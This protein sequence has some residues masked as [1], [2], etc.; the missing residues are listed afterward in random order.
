MINF[1]EITFIEKS[2]K[3]LFMVGLI[4]LVRKRLNTKSSKWA[5][6]SLWTIFITYLLFPYTIVFNLQEPIKNRF[7]EAIIKPLVFIN[8][9]SRVIENNLGYILSKNNQLIVSIILIGYVLFEMYKV[10]QAMKGSTIIE[11][12]HHVNKLISKFKLRRSIKVLINDDLK[13]PITYGVFKPKIILQSYILK[14]KELLKYVMIHELTHIKKYDIVYNHLKNLIACLYWHNLLILAATRY[15]EED[16]EILCDKL[17][18][19]KVGDTSEHRKEY[20]ISMLKL[21]DKYK[22][23]DEKVL[24]L[25]PTLERMI[26]MRK[27]KK[28]LS[29][30]LTFALVIILSTTAFADVRVTNCNTLISSSETPIETYINEA[31]RVTVISDEE[32]RDLKLEELNV[33][34]LSLR[35]ANVSETTSLGGLEN[36]YYKFNM[37]SRNSPTHNGFTVKLSNMSSR[38]NL[39]YSII[40]QENGRVI[41][42]ESFNKA[43]ILKVTPDRNYRYK[44]TIVNNS[45]DS[46]TYSIKINSYVR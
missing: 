5:N 33:E 31:D 15:I 36:K 30:I 19:E 7:V 46:M 16:I 23:R 26:V 2:F 9:Y 28:T 35:A 37:S 20:C 40:I 8:E 43:T 45:V 4:L 14:D 38:S 42:K 22:G 13:T 29:G 27:C 17:V 1:V 24:K 39:D 21:M 41:Y 10:E 11:N 6:I 12:N 18:V 34:S 32:Y 44:V 3:S 25:N